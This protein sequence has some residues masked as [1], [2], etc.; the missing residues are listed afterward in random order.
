M[1]TNWDAAQKYKGVNYRYIQQHGQISI[2]LSE[3]SQANK[4]TYIM[5]TFI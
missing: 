2:M 5:I 1:P 3:R 4:S